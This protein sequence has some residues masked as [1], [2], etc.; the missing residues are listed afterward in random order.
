MSVN[1]DGLI[2]FYWVSPILATNVGLWCIFPEKGTGRDWVICLNVFLYRLIFEGA[3]CK[4]RILLYKCVAK[5]NR[6]EFVKASCSTLAAWSIRLWP[7][8]ERAFMMDSCVFQFRL[9]LE[10]SPIL[11]AISV[12]AECSSVAAETLPP[13]SRV[14]ILLQDRRV[15]PCASEIKFLY[16]ASFT[17][18]RSASFKCIY[19]YLPRF[20]TRWNKS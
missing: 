17:L 9:P 3:C 8:D 13:A 14:A 18:K 16:F 20:P 5:I 7:W 1:Q 15:L 6:Y 10:F 11:N 4:Y 19:P 2:G 12:R